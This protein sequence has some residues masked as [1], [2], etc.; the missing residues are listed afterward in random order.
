MMINE[1]IGIPGVHKEI[2]SGPIGA[3]EL[4]L[5]VPADVDQRYLAILGHP[6]SLQGG[7]M[8]NKVV[9]TMAR[10]FRELGIASIRFNFR[11]V[12]QTAGEYAAGLGESEDMLHILRL[13]DRPDLTVF[14]AG[15]SFGSYVT[16]RTLT[17]YQSEFSHTTALISIAPS[18]HHYDYSQPLQ[19]KTPWLIVIGE[20]D[21]LV[22]LTAVTEFAR[23]H[24][25]APTV[26]YFEHTTHFFHGKLLDLKAVLQQHIR[27]WIAQ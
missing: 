21:E 23:T 6:H 4:I 10:A 27:K 18:V 20:E 13:C 17:Q 7:T 19:P 1:K 16:Y 26:A 12:G 25:S 11:G 14:F 22:P 5:E 3:L 15:F 9:T 24:P 8:D 2:I